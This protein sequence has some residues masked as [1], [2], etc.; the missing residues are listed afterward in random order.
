MGAIL[1]VN[2]NYYDLRKFLGRQRR[3]KGLP[4][5]GTLLEGESIYSSKLGNKGIILFGNE[6]KGISDELMPYITN[7][8]VIPK[9]TSP[10]YGI[11]SLNVGMAASVVFSEFARRTRASYGRLPCFRNIISSRPILD[12]RQLQQLSYRQLQMIQF[13]RHNLILHRMDK[14]LKSLYVS[15]FSGSL[16]I[17]T[18][19]E[20]LDSTPSITASFV[21]YPFIT[22]PNSWNPSLS[23]LPI[24]GSGSHSCSGDD[25]TPGKI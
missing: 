10:K 20:V 13:L 12:K 22:D 23:R 14:V 16:G 11:D 2:C 25:V 9:F 1:H 8:L 17:L 21:R 3:K 6:S 18:G 15:K 19:E 7:R 5:Y 24:I 4:V